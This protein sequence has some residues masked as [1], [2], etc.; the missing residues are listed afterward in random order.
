MKFYTVNILSILYF[1]GQRI[2]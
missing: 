2:P 1:P